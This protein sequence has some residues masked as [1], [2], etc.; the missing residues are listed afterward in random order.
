MVKVFLCGFDDVI[1]IRL[2]LCTKV[3]A[4]KHIKG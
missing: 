3:Y 1:D 4:C 2:K